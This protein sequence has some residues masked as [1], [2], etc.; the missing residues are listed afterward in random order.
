M[1]RGSL[2]HLAQGRDHGGQ[3]GRKERQV[4]CAGEN[5]AFRV[6]RVPGEAL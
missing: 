4:E 2:K 6:A 3:A 5:A 1:S